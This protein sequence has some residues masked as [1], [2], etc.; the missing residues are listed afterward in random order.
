MPWPFRVGPPGRVGPALVQASCPGQSAQR[1]AWPEAAQVPN[2]KLTCQTVSG[3]PHVLWA[4]GSV[5]TRT[6]SVG[7]ADRD[8]NS[9]H[10]DP[11]PDLWAPR[12]PG[13]PA[14]MHPD[15]PAPAAPPLTLGTS[16]Q[17][18]LLSP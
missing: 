15:R 17:G 16:L 1:S 10:A 2:L 8:G 11:G 12:P 9:P 3:Q 13:A 14:P 5:E 6:A 7:K 4:G 18:A